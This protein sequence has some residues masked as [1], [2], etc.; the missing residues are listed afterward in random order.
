[1]S[2]GQSTI[3]VKSENP[4][5]WREA[6]AALKSGNTARWFHIPTHIREWIIAAVETDMD[7]INEQYTYAN[8]DRGK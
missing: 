3:D 1:M 6:R 4:M 8:R 7:L 2:P 5:Y